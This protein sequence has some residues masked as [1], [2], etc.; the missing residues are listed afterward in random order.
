MPEYCNGESEFCPNDV[1]KRNTEECDGGQAYCY[2]G[3]CKSHND[4]CKILWGPS[5]ASSEQCYD[6]N[7]NGSR[8]GNCGY[9]K[10]KTEYIPC[11]P[12]DIKCGMLQCR[13]LN[14]RLEF[15]MESVAILSHSFMN[16][17]GSIIPCRTAIID[18]GLQ[19][20]DPG[21][22]PDGAKC[23]ENM[24]CVNQKCLSIDKLRSE[25]KILGCPDCNG[26]GVCNSKGH[27]HCNDGYA[28]PFCDGPGVGGSIDSGPASD[29]DSK[30]DDENFIFDSVLSFS[31]WIPL[32]GLWERFKTKYIE[33]DMNLSIL[34]SLL[35]YL[36]LLSKLYL[37]S[38]CILQTQLYSKF[39]N[40]AM[41]C[42][43]NI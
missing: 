28:P 15:G 25:G 9:D 22:T 32:N 31:K 8:H 33:N 24:M 7:T 2:D 3:S 29:P 38:V 21:L 41:A 14:E 10:L 20:I 17:R 18:L 13:H 39:Q 12:Q 30:S 6:K 26:N 27:C 42:P 1:F 36:C 43:P 5:G 23:D 35:L 16:Y 34:Y 11:R 19:S 40:Y 37:C 4:Q